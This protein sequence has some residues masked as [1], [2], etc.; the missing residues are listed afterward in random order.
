MSNHHTTKKALLLSAV[1]ILLCLT[2]LIGSTFA[3]FTDTASTG[4]NTIA[5][6]NLDLALMYNT[7][8]D[9]NDSAW[10]EAEGA[11]KLFENVLWEPGHTEVVYFHVTNLGTLALKYR[12]S[13]NVASETEGISIAGEPIKLSEHL[14]FGIVDVSSA[15]SDRAAAR[16]AVTAPTSFSDFVSA[17]KMLGFEE[18]A[19]FA[20][21]VWMPEEIGNAA[22]HNGTDIPSIEFGIKVEATQATA[23]SD[24]FDDQY[25][26]DAEYDLY[27]DHTSVVVTN[28]E[29][30]N[31][32]VSSVTDPTLIKLVSNTYKL[33]TPN[34]QNKTIVFKADKDSTFDFTEFNV[35]ATQR[36]VGATITFDGVNVRFHE[37]SYYLN[38]Y[39]GL[40]LAGGK[41]A[42]RNCTISG[43][44]YLYVPTAEFINCIFENAADSYSVC[45]YAAKD[46][47]FTGCTFHT[48]GKAVLLYNDGPVTTDVTLTDC[49]FHSDDTV[50][51]DKAAVETGDDPS[52]GSKFNITFSGCKSDGFDANNSTSPLWGNKINSNMPQDRLNVVIDGQDV[53]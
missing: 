29:E 22:N 11:D 25:D 13:T 39:T 48:A 53:Y 15:F 8:A 24:S 52:K 46:V 4:V 23:E 19:S 27:A 34:M 41:L 35:N 43:A 37:N 44:Q 17:E 1:S 42:Y 14:R 26:K 32:V 3:W 30:L 21:V 31:A 20:L 18:G 40:N 49:I 16:A 51:D 36:L 12:I 47:T 50:A 7:T 38:G 28:Q 9:R 45:T 2:M 5:A 33:P 10:M 6:G